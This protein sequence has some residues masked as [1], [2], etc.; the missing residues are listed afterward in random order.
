MWSRKP[1]DLNEWTLTLQF[2]VSGQGKRLFGDGFAVWFTT[3]PYHRDGPVHGFQDKF[4]GASSRA[5]PRNE[6]Q[7]CRLLEESGLLVGA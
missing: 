2:R 5:S 6:W 4:L 3:D 1:L 7:T